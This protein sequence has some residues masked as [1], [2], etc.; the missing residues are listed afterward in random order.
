MF[1]V[2]S[3]TQDY[4]EFLPW[5]RKFKR[6]EQ[7]GAVEHVQLTVGFPPF[8]ETYTSRVTFEAPSKVHSFSQEGTFFKDLDAL[9][10]F[11]DCGKNSCI[12]SFKI[13]FK[14]KSVLQAPIANVF[15][16]QTAYHMS[17]AFIS[18]AEELYGKPSCAEKKLK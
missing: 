13:N 6:L 12:L 7:Q 11:E 1:A 10:T 3:N 2:V 18:R 16:K 4:P 5:C 17:R 9:W 15:F 8:E 14:L